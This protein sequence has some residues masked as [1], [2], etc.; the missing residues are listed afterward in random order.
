M[1]DLQQNLWL[2]LQEQKVFYVVVAE[3][4]LETSNNNQYFLT[5]NVAR[6]K[7]WISNYAFE[8][9]CSLRS[10][11]CLGLHIQKRHSEIRGNTKA[12]L[13]VFFDHEV[14]E[15]S[16]CVHSFRPDSQSG[17]LMESSLLDERWQ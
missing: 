17:I 6:D 3:D 14:Y 1:N 2:L 5:H 10:R 9:K 11:S 15:S 8:K 16:A 12:M 7:V 13:I 4:L